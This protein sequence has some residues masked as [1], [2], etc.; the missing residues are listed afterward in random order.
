MISGAPFGAGR[1][2]RLWQRFGDGWVS[3]YGCGREGW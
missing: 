2:D 1:G 3:E